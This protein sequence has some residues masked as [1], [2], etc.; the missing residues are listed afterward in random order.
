MAV[1][2]SAGLKFLSL[3]TNAPAQGGNAP[4]HLLHAPS[5]AVSSM[6]VLQWVAEGV[7]GISV[8]AEPHHH[9]VFPYTAAL[10]L[11]CLLALPC[12]LLSILRVS[13]DKVMGLA[14]HPPGLPHTGGTAVEGE[15]N[16]QGGRQ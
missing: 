1:V 7:F 5:C 13:L 9:P 14:P 12:L 6:A 11:L 8:S 10:G 2:P 16:L 3:E 4:A 15:P